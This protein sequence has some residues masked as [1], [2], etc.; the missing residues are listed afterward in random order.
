MGWSQPNGKP[1]IILKGKSNYAVWVPACLFELRAEKAG[2][3]LEM[4]E[5]E[6]PQSLTE[7]QQ[8][9]AINTFIARTEA[10]PTDGQ[11]S[12]ALIAAN[13]GKWLAAA[14]TKYEKWY[15]LNEKAMGVI[16]SLCDPGTQG[17]IAAEKT[18]KDQWTR[19]EEAYKKQGFSAAYDLLPQLNQYTLKGCNNNFEDYVNKIRV[20]KSSFDALGHE[21]KDDVWVGVFL[22]GLEGMHDL[23]ISKQFDAEAGTLKFDAV[24][25]GAF[26]DHLRIKGTPTTNG[27]ANAFKAQGK[28]KGNSG[29]NGNSGKDKKSL[30]T[31]DG[32][33]NRWGCITHQTHK[34]QW[35]NCSENPKRVD[36]DSS[37]RKDATN[38]GSNNNKKGDGGAANASLLKQ[39]TPE[40]IEHL[41]KAT[42]K[43]DGGV[44]IAQGY[45]YSLARSQMAS[46]GPKQHGFLIDSGASHHMTYYKGNYINFRPAKLTA[47]VADGREVESEGC[48]DV[49]IDCLVDGVTVPVRFDNVWFFPDLG[50]NLLSVYALKEQEMHVVLELMNGLPAAGL[51]KDGRRIATVNRQ[52]RRYVLDTTGQQSSLLDTHREDSASTLAVKGGDTARLWHRRMGHLSID[53]LKKLQ[54]NADGIEFNDSFGLDCEDCLLANQTRFPRKGVTSSQST[55]P[56]ELIHSDLSGPIDE[57]V[58]ING[59]KYIM[60]ITDDF[61]RRVTLYFLAQKSEASISMQHY[62]NAAAL[63][64]KPVT[65]VRV[66]N[67]GEYK[68]SELV[69]FVKETGI[70]QQPTVPYSPESNGVAERLN[71][72]IMTKVRA[73]FKD[74]GLPAYL[75]EPLAATAAYL[76]NRSPCRAISFLTPHEKFFGK[77]PSLSHIRI[78]GCKAYVHV[79]KEKRQGKL[80]DR[81]RLVRLVGYGPSQSIYKVYDPESHRIFMVK[82]VVFKEEISNCLAPAEVEDEFDSDED[83]ADGTTVEYSSIYREEP[84]DIGNGRREPDGP[85]P[86]KDVQG[87]QPME[88]SM[89]RRGTRTRQPSRKA[90]ENAAARAVEIQLNAAAITGHTVVPYRQAMK[91]ED[92]AKWTETIEAQYQAYCDNNTWEVIDIAPGMNIL[93]GH[94]VLVRKPDRYKA[95]WVIHGNKQIKG[96]DYDE[97]YAATA[98]S[99]SIRTLLA[100]TA[101]EG[102]EMAQLDVI[103]A[104]L[105]AELVEEVYT[106]HPIGFGKKGT[107][108]R[109]LKT[110]F[111]LCQSPR[112]WWQHISRKLAEMGFIQ[113]KSDQSVYVN[114]DGVIIILYVDDIALFARKKEAIATAKTQLMSSYKLRDIGKLQAF[115]GIQI[116]RVSGKVFIYQEDYLN[117]IIEKYGFSIDNK[118]K[119]PF[120][121]KVVLKPATEQASEAVVKRFQE[122]NGSV[123]WAAN[124]SRPDITYAHSRLAQFNANPTLL[125]IQCM[126]HLYRYVAGTTSW[127]LVYEGNGSSDT[128]GFT[129]SN[130]GDPNSTDS[131]STSGYLFTLANGP[132]SW[133]SRKQRTTATSSTEAEYIA[134][135]NATKEAVYLRQL[136]TELGRTPVG[137]T[138]LF[139]DNTSAIALAQNPSLHSRTRHIDMQYHWTREKVA[140][141]TVKITYIPTAEMAA[142]GL[143][144]P[145]KPT[146]FGRF[147]R[148]MGMVTLAEF[149]TSSESA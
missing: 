107:C 5:V 55:R 51:Y 87:G 44:A 91:G 7:E 3:A 77:K 46:V 79:P 134:Q 10:L 1:R 144:K 42:S 126:N 105:N 63:D 80:A 131:K 133:S 39:L 16:Y 129:D 15:E 34:H 36:K 84:L 89:L 82:D 60:T 9:K 62:I 132:I 130:W 142:D 116:L 110:L 72:T 111:G 136:L 47:E 52:G 45:V 140:D 128:Q 56:N 59:K 138:T 93:T 11:F 20:L 143:T 70:Y 53:Y 123:A 71:R 148:L 122:M 86:V 30:P 95:R 118:V 26:N 102:Y 106:I 115:I 120:D 66:D 13:K 75:W 57:T 96:T 109:L 121:D 74:S 147:R 85:A 149:Q 104:F 43:D 112:E 103:D 73:I 94:W 4:D 27:Q 90:L 69:Q 23:F 48:G 22:R 38:K 125:A 12:D 14:E 99:G 114:K 6:D 145:L 41:R 64:G 67:G 108:C 101:I 29:G 146:D 78:P 98:R 21:F 68:G 2:R 100:I 54:K 35:H 49:I 17:I 65:A 50:V 141:G 33:G 139:A 25:E 97:V 19:L 135:C 24:V 37:D 31:Y 40:M 28:G 88:P 18:A 61:T 92:K 127:G 124:M 117:Y 83:I 8:R 76:H 119:T 137:P 113:C 81:A 32:E 58:S